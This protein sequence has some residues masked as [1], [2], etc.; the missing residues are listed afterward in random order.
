M[1]VTFCKWVDNIADGV[2]GTCFMLADILYEFRGIRSPS[3]NKLFLKY[4]R[5][6]FVM[7]MPV[8]ARLF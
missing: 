5:F 4:V 2:G 8:K 7:G 3:G 6:E 1:A